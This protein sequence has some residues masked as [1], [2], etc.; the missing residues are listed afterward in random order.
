LLLLY[1]QHLHFINTK[2]EPYV[3]GGE[4]GYAAAEGGGSYDN[5]NT[6]IVLK[7][8]HRCANSY[9]IMQGDKEFRATVT[10]E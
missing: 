1:H 10:K 7:A 8:S 9:S 4:F 5:R 3:C 2:P 6:N